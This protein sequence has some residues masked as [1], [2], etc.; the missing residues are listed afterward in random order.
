MKTADQQG[1]CQ[2]FVASSLR[3]GYRRHSERFWAGWIAPQ[4][5]ELL[6][7]LAT[8]LIRNRWSLKA[9]H[10]M[11]CCSQTYRQQ[12]V[13]TDQRSAMLD[14]NNRWLWRQN[15]R[16]VEAETLRD[17]VL[18]C[19]RAANLQMYGQAFKILIIKKSMLRSTNTKFKT[20]RNYG[21]ERSIVSEF[22]LRLSHFY[23]PSIVP[24]LPA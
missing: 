1:D 12:S 14:A 4:S 7:W 19:C 3:S 18:F 9:I 17:S 21:V 22:E 5:P 16:R 11:M 13:A 23:R 15:P 24:I 20:I 2:S 8:E 10:R 6:D